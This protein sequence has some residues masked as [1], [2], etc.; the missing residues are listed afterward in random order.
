MFYSRE[1][2]ELTLNL[3]SIAKLHLNELERN[4]LINSESKF[5]DFDMNC[6]H[7]YSFI[8][9]IVNSWV[10]NLL[11]DEIEIIQKRIVDKNTFDKIAVQLGYAN[12]SSVIR[13]YKSILDKLSTSE[14]SIC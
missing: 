7:Y 13:K 11:P 10:N 4:K 5:S 1:E 9:K 8:I 14:I 12:H 3:Y 2:V 6:Y